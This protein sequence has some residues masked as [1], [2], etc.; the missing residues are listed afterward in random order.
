MGT[1]LQEKKTPPKRKIRIDRSIPEWRSKLTGMTSALLFFEIVTGLALYL[2]PFSRLNQFGLL[3][4]SILGIAMLLPVIWYSISHWLKRKGGNFNHFQLLGYL[5]IALLLVSFVSGMVVTWQG[6]MVERLDFIWDIMHLISSL[7]FSVFVLLHLTTLIFRKVGR[8]GAPTDLVTARRKFYI[9]TFLGSGFFVLACVI[10]LSVFD[11]PETQKAFSEDYNWRFGED[12]PF[13]PSFAK[14]DDSEIRNNLYLQVSDLLAVDEAKIFTANLSFNQA[15]DI[16]MFSSVQKSLKGLNKPN[17][18]TLDKI[19]S[20]TAQQIQAHGAMTSKAM[21]GSA[22]CGSSN[23][24]TEIYQEWLPSAHRYSS[25]DDMFQKVQTLMVDETSSEHTRYCAGC[26]DPISLFS[27]AKNSSNITLSTEGADEGASCMVCHSIVQTDIQ[28]NGNYT[29][30]APQRYLF[31]LSEGKVAKSISDFLIRT[32]PQQH[33]QSFSRALYKTPEYCGA[34]HKQ[35]LDTEVNTDIG[36]VQGQ[37][38]YDS[39]KNSRWKKDKTEDTTTCREC[40]MPLVASNDPARG[41]VLD[42]NRS[43][44]DGKHRSH[45]TLGTN[46]YIPAVH[47]LDGQELH[48]ELTEKW[49]RGKIEIPEIAHKWTTGE[50]VRL[51]VKSSGEPQVGQELDLRVFVTNNKAG[52]SF[53]T[54]PMD[55]IQSWLEVTVSDEKGNE[56]YKG[57]YL[58][59]K[60]YVK[61]LPV[62]YRADGFDRKGEIINRHNLWDLVGASYKRTLYPGMSDNIKVPFMIPESL[63][64]GQKLMV[65]VKLQYRKANPEFLDQIYPGEEVRTPITTIAE[66]NKILTVIKQP[67]SQEITKITEAE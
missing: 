28:G 2:L 30:K 12:R 33:L 23:C 29:V 16:G 46:Q 8:Y 21:A 20:H 6:I 15:P 56:I 35:Y 11:T 19:F 66:V 3:L 55:M 47:K 24:H 48:T 22:S 45:R 32:Y 37:N 31:E 42:Y 51:E 17:K 53:P 41:D 39:W 5:S 54:G 61:G 67:E 44:N 62:I 52:H 38:Q 27:G 34:C 50:A 65:N 18:E 57:G 40:H 25:M 9:N 49:M 59:D 7:V 13:A 58:D 26:H 4:H 43:A 10:S 63:K 14:I 60:G 1:N 64:S 36:K